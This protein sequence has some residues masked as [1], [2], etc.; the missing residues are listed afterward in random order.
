MAT[1]AEAFYL[2]RAGSRAIPQIRDSLSRPAR[3]AIQWLMSRD[4]DLLPWIL[5]G[6]LVIGAAAMTA[7]ALSAPQSPPVAAD[8]ALAPVSPPAAP[9]AATSASA[10]S[11]S[12]DPYPV[13]ISSK[14][15]QQL[16]SGQVWECK[17]NGQR[18]FSDV[19]CDTHATVRQLSSLNVMDSSAAPR[20][21]PYRYPYGSPY[22][23]GAVTAPPSEEAPPSDE[24]PADYSSDAYV[25]QQSIVARDRYHRFQHPRRNTR[26]HARP[27][28]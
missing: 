21:A 7:V 25:G 14:P 11:A 10:S 2:V 13:I 5:G 19:Q 26:P 12:A 18:V 16:P 15:R 20:P 1:Q 22:T 17:V 8:A 6:C 28:N 9:A 3:N 27:H 24:A 4:V 23:P